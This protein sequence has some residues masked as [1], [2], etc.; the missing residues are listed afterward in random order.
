MRA[1]VGEWLTF[2]PFNGASINTLTGGA[3]SQDLPLPA[4]AGGDLVALGARSCSCCCGGSHLA[5]T[6]SARRARS[7][8]LFVVAWLVV[9]ARWVLNLARRDPR[10]LCE[11]TAASPPRRGIAPPRMA[12]STRSSSARGRSCR[13]RRCA[14]SW[15]PT[16]TISAD[17]RPTIFIPTTCEFEPFRDVIAPPAL[18]ETGRLARRLPPPRH[19]VRRRAQAAALGR[20]PPVHAE[21]KLLEPHGAAL[22]LVRLTD[23]PGHRHRVGWLRVVDCGIRHARSRCVAAS[24]GAHPARRRG[25]RARASSSARSC[26]PCGCARCP[27]SAIPFGLAVHR[28]CRSAL[29]TACAAVA[30][31]S[32]AAPSHGTV[33]AA[34][35]CRHPLA[36][37]TSSAGSGWSFAAICAWLALRYVLLLVDVAL[38]PLYPWDAWIQWATKARVWFELRHIVPFVGVEQWLA[39]NGALYT[40]AAPDYPATVPLWQVFSSVALGRWDDALM[41]IPWWIAVA[42]IHG[43]A[44]RRAAPSR[45]SCRWPRLRARRSSRRYRS[46]TCTSRWRAMPTCRWPPT[47]RWRRWRRCMR[48]TRAIAAKE[49]ARLLAL[50]LAVACPTI[51]HAGRRVAGDAHGAADRRA[52]AAPGVKLVA[53]RLRR[54]AVRA[55]GAR[56]DLRNIM[57]YTLHLDFAPPWNGLFES[58]FMLGTWNLLWYGIFAAA[59]IGVREWLAPRIAPLTMLVGAGA[60]FL[61]FVFAFT[62]ARAWV[63][64]QTTVN[65]ALLHLAPLLCVW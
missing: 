13:S 20:Q 16:S 56:A 1:R 27:L 50:L 52:H 33:A 49:A 57:G 12:R 53:R 61:C 47:S 63:E 4:F 23:G 14:C 11:P 28:C 51:K 44:V 5:P 17:A 31:R 34:R 64:S 7:A 43:R 45:A 40:D 65:R 22:F 10:R 19:P 37:A 39:A 36:C 62:N 55:P 6:A 46:S 58:L 8:V 59:I 54:R 9:D 26:S 25:R 42:G 3:D 18:D 30:S 32:G 38:Q 2:E 29:A 60:L 21:L 35:R 15:P 48:S 24:T 41:N